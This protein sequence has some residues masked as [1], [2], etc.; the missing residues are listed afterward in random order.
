MTS[1][2]PTLHT[3][4]PLGLLPSVLSLP[5]LQRRLGRVMT[6]MRVGEDELVGILGLDP[7]AVVRGL[8]AA[9]AAVFRQTQPLPTVRSLVR[10][11]GG[12]LS[13]RLIVEARPAIPQHPDLIAL[14]HH[15]VATAIA[16]EDL[17][18]RT[19]LLEP[20]VAYL[21]GLLHDLPRWLQTISRLSGSTGADGVPP[22]DWILHWQLPAPLVSLMLA[23]EMGDRATT[24][25]DPADP[26]ALI[27]AAEL[28]A[29][30]ADF[31]HPEESGARS[32]LHAVANAERG[33]LLIAQQL[34]RRFEGA[35]RSFGFAP[36]ITESEVRASGNP[37][38]DLQR[39]QRDLDEV[40]LSV[41]GCI[42]SETYR[43]IVTALAAAAVRFGNYDRAFFG[44][45]NP[46]TGIVTLRS[47]ADSSARRLVCT[48]LSPSEVERAALE[49]A[50]ASERPVHLRGYLASPGGLLGPLSTDEVLAVPLN[51]EFATPAFLL[52]DRSMTLRSIEPE[53]DLTL[54]TMLGMTGS[55]LIE[56]LLLRRRR[57]RAQ[58]F[59][60]TD[61]LTRLFNRRMGL[62]ALERA[63]AQSERDS[64][65]L[66]VLMCDL[67]HFKR[68][69]DTLGHVQGDLALK[70]T[71]DVLQQTARKADT[72]C[73]YGGEE[74]L[75][76]LTDT[77]P[78]EAMVL[79]A[80]MF[81]NVHARGEELGL[82]MTVSIG[83]TSCRPGDSVETLL[84]RADKALYAS[85]GHGR[86]RFSADVDLGR[87]PEPPPA[88]GP[89][90]AA[91]R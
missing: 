12:T 15:S 91:P 63:I 11:L 82:P 30:L 75:V 36:E 80:R 5:D 84:T 38:A 35:M 21:L 90:P 65:P 70:A 10:S 53:R 3:G 77:T 40:V 79:A 29:E 7:M 8:R 2:P 22:T 78:D 46:R 74:F 67:D 41:L 26:A 55:L 4:N 6:E 31:P 83:L 33:E 14:W 24:T 45:W 34:R 23:V 54:A 28:M 87:E 49:Q 61:P 59:A 86:N 48:R 20:E 81:T 58:K 44:R 85:K 76:V 72:V 73:R 9:N 71:A 50:L 62:H 57:Q 66:T 18:R 56:N 43:G 27:R 51:R 88:D 42:R 39:R 1:T 64:R 19:G 69:N 47:K 25:Q 16:A 68:L 60:L 17:A 32:L 37:L 89:P 52:L 13:R